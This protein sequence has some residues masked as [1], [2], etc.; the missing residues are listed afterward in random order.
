MRTTLSNTSWS[1]DC[2]PVLGIVGLGLDSEGGDR[3]AT[4][5]LATPV[6]WFL[7][8][9]GVHAQGWTGSVDGPTDGG[10]WSAKADGVRITV[11]VDTDRGLTFQFANVGD[12]PVE[13]PG[14]ALPL[15]ALHAPATLLQ[16]NDSDASSAPRNLFV[17]VPDKGHFSASSDDG[18]TWRAAMKGRRNRGGLGNPCGVDPL[19]RGEEWLRASAAPAGW[20]PCELRLV[21]TLDGV[22]QPQTST[23]L[24]LSVVDLLCPADMDAATWAGI[25]RCYLNNWQVSSD[26]HAERAGLLANNVV[27][28]PAG[29]SFWF[30]ADAMLFWHEVAKDVDVRPLLRRSLDYWLSQ[31]VSA[32][33]HVNAFGHMYDLY[34]VTGPSL[35][36]SAWDYWQLADDTAWLE[37]A[38]PRLH[39]MG[40]YLLRRD[41]DRD[42]LVESIHSGNAW[43]LRDPDRADVWFEMMH[44][45]HKNAYLNALAYR[46]LLCLAEMLEATGHPGGG[47]WY[48]EHADRLKVAFQS[49]MY[50]P[51]SGWFVSW[52]SADGEVHN[53]GHTFVNGLAVAYGLVSP[54]EGAGILSRLHGVLRESGFDNW[55]CG[56]PANVRPCRRADMIQPRITM[57][58]EPA[59][60]TFRWP[61]GLSE[62]ASYGYRY[63]NGTLHPMLTTFY[64]HGL[65][66]AGLHDLADP[67]LSAMTD[68][69]RRGGLQN[70]I[71]NL[72]YCGAEH[73][74]I[75]GKT[76]GYEG[77]L[78]D[79][80]LFLTGHF[81]RNA[82]SRHRLL[83]PMA[84]HRAAATP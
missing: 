76:C 84:R 8:G 44:F 3:K 28:D 63:P 55:Q 11:E 67:I 78:A 34:C 17:N 23:T 73:F 31:H 26:W 70:G 39:L 38:L 69:A 24:R 51:Q 30:Y 71:V 58:G 46:S 6:E 18:R 56:V 32:N 49:Q 33:G 2:D 1:V 72:G 43:G 42:G 10:G 83:G 36:I 13:S 62:A 9:R 22:L 50:D 47:R 61:E 75:D 27:S 66:V 14:F 57:D 4:N 54:E 35:L 40:D 12:R 77:I 82:E 16:A 59:D 7:D 81:T 29:C 80:W 64:L 68:N 21:L 52:I 19:L 20:Q 65:Q 48:R 45:G 5:L 25:G 60:D 79:N 37:N 53:Y 41:V 74:L 15:N